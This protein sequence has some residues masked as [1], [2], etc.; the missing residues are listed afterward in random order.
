MIKLK[1][2]SK[3]WI[4]ITVISILTITIVGILTYYLYEKYYLEKQIALLEHQGHLL[5]N[6]YST[7]GESTEFNKFVKWTEKSTHIKI[8]VTDDPMQ[9]SAGIPINGFNDSNLITFKERQKL[10][11]GKGITIVRDH[12][13]FKQKILAV[14]VPL[15]KKNILSGAIFLYT[16]I[17]TIYEPFKSLRTFMF[18][19]II[20][21]SLLLVWIGN[22]ATHYL[23]K[24]L[25]EM[26]NVSKKMAQGDF[27]EK[28]TIQNNDEIGQLAYS[29]NTMAE[30]LNN[31][32]KNRIQFLQNVSHE[33]RTPLTYINGYTEAILEG[34]YNDPQEINKSLVIIKKETERL[35]RL[36][37]DLLDLA[38]LEGDTY[39]KKKYPIVYSQLILD[40]VSKYELVLKQK[41]VKVSADLDEDII[42]EGDEDR[43][44]QVISNLLD[45]A[46]NY[47]HKD[48][49]IHIT[50]TRKGTISILSIKDFGPGIP[51]D[52]LEHIFDRFYRVDKSR[53]RNTGGT[54]LGLSICKHIIKK[55]SG[56][57]YATSEEGI[58]S[59]FM[60]EI[61]C[62]S[63]EDKI[64]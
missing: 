63:D 64:Y 36:V 7:L 47:S 18:I 24:P 57:I 37:H 3:I 23:L 12:P 26:E 62:L 43:L 30:S 45:N 28:I 1:I 25:K 34:M 8:I 59:E 22:K 27:S 14:A 19:F 48:T 41:N 5:K 52:E 50:L 13:K 49:E 61:P 39:P 46:L 11:S 10:L 16:P 9:L 56:H 17:D 51:K 42:I 31:V 21:I 53:G 44:A 32:E 29:L 54:G 20:F 15:F 38:Q 58:G 33:L 4:S 35:S 55:H 40:V 2:K 60:I 6:S